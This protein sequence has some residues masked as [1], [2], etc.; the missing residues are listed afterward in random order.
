VSAGQS[1]GGRA[2]IAW[3]AIAAAVAAIAVLG[4]VAAREI[5]AR[6]DQRR[7]L[8]LVD[9]RIAVNGLGGEVSILRDGHGVPHI[10]AR[11]E[12]DAWFG[13]GF[14]Q[15]Q[16]RLAQLTYLA[17]AARGRSAE[18][19]GADALAVDRW[20]RTLGF[21]RLAKA[22][23]ARADGDTRRVLEAYTAGVNA[24]IEE[25][26]SG[27]AAPPAPLARLHV[28]VEDW[29]AEDA[30]AIEKLV[31]W[32]LDGSVDAPLVLSDLIEKLGGFG[33][34]PFFPRE[35]ARG[36]APTPPRDTEAS[37]S[38]PRD[39]LRTALALAGRSVGSSAWLVGARDS[40]SGAPLLAGDLHMAPT[41][42]ALL[43]ESHLSAPGLEVAGAG[44]V[45]VPVYWSG[46][47]EHV[48][49]AATHA[50]AVATDLYVETLDPKRPGRYAHGDG[51]D[52]L[53]TR[54]EQIDVRD[55]DTLILPVRE[56][57]HGPLLD[58]LLG[59]GRPALSAAWGGAQPGDGIGGLLHA[60]QARDAAGFRAALATHHEPVFVF[61][62]ADRAGRGGRQVAGWLPARSM[63]TG[64]VPVPG[65][66]SFYDWQKPIAFDALPYQ[67]LGDAGFVV[68]A[69]NPVTED[70]AIEWWWRPGERS[71]RIEALLREARDRGPIDA[72]AAAAIL[73]DQRSAAAPARVRALLDLAGPIDALPP[74]ARGVAKLLR[75]WDGESD[76]ASA[77]AAAWHLLLGA[78]LE[79]CL[80]PALGHDLVHRYLALRGVRLEALLDA[81][82]EAALGPADNVIVPID[83]LREAVR[84]GLRRTGLTLRVRLGSDPARWH[85][86]GLH[87]LRF[88][89]FGWPASA[90]SPDAPPSWP[91]GGDGVTV[92]VGEYDPSDPF[93]VRVASVY[94][95]IVD[96]A[97][98][99]VALSALVP[100]TVEHAADP[101]SGEGV[102]RWLAGRPGVLATHRFLVE[103]GAR[104]R[105]VLAPR[106]RATPK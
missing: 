1:I 6:R 106:G 76:A 29:S 7:A 91:Y 16:D 70:S 59:A 74:E 93:A 87:E 27:R 28:A 44:P 20:S 47:N 73:A 25:V 45:G 98:P 38:A 57:H 86:G 12:R 92:A 75:E 40:E 80:E 21:T 41:A 32:G 54:Q 97:A 69:D 18:V 89:A 79:S 19:L 104:A 8:P 56:T 53:V 105:L 67:P 62:F 100:G 39:P 102:E 85:W 42:P 37:R 9:G 88:A 65:R 46:H 2:R 48:A 43:Y 49:W 13:L 31:A 64:L 50:R 71:A 14:A 84:D 22:Q 99:D 3:R 51:T 101:L 55:G 66:S 90:W 96:L 82:M 78:V 63:P 36:L 68:A 58:Q 34:R 24:W 10:V 81:V 83:A 60:L 17:R 4:V 26:R 15:A 77:G 52:A 72:R 103:D 94:R 30:L 33:A 23:L 35:A 61:V 95:W 5:A 11:S